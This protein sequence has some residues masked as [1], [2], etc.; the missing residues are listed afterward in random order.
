[1][2]DA[3]KALLILRSEMA[4]REARMDASL[5][6]KM[7]S[8]DQAVERFRSDI[9]SIVSGASIQIATEARHAMF[10]VADDYH[11]AVSKSSAQLRMAGRTVWLWLTATSATLMLVLLVGW[12]VLGYYR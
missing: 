8:L 6:Q 3:V 11:N 4:Q 5:N 12:A 2:Q 1:M 10:S 9:N 7:L